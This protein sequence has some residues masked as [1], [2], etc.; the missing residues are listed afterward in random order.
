ME[1]YTS[2]KYQE[3]DFYNAKS[4]LEGTTWIEEA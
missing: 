3:I 1:G 2:R 4:R